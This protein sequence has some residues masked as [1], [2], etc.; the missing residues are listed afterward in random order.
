MKQYLF[1]CLFTTQICFGQQPLRPPLAKSLKDHITFLADDKLEGRRAGSPGEAL[2]SAYVIKEFKKA[3]LQ[4]APG[5]T[6]FLQAFEIAE[7]KQLG[8]SNSLIVGSK[9]FALNTD[10]FPMAF[11][12]PGSV[13]LIKNKKLLADTLDIGALLLQNV[14]NPHFE[15]KAAITAQANNARQSGKPAL[16]LINNSGT[17]DKLHFDK[18]DKTP[19]V[20]IPVIFIR[21]RQQFMLA[22]DATL[23]VS[24][25]DT[26]RTGHNVIGYIDNKATTTVVLGAHY[27]HLGYGEDNNSLYSGEIKMIHNGA[28][29][30]ASGTAA[31]IELAKMVKNSGIKNNNYIFVAFS[32]E[33]LGLFGS[34]FFV[35][36]FTAGLG[37][38]NYMINMDMLGRLN[39]ST[40][41]LTIGGYGTSPLWNGIIKQD[42][43]YFK[44]KLDSS[45]SG[46]SD[47]TSFYRKNIPVLFFFTGTH[48]DY[49]KPSDDAD[50]INFEGEARVVNY[51]YTVIVQANNL[52]RLSFTKTREAAAMG[53][54][55]F[56]VTLGIMPD[57]TFSGNGVLVDGVSDGRPAQK[58]GV[59]TG[60]VLLQLGDHSFSDVND[61]MKALNKFNKGES[62]KLKLQR[63][64]K[65]MLFEITF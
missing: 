59:Q 23:S 58:A 7:G 13:A 5:H 44:I 28:D 63:A 8:D 46:P 30:N 47:H 11:S 21:N 27:D 36:N 52:D 65:E 48:K 60:D 10:Y 12:G 17:D 54:S 64:G 53:K 49:H 37:S 14:M 6:D 18:N 4:I 20:K 38:I 3:G 16:I 22:A 42:D 43:S 39:D 55:N 56:K 50:K 1:L 62:T 31:L 15:L 41:G 35:D 61:Y 51:I 24:V 45:G 25:E 9:T 26:K 34:K 2:A 32:G 19:A 33:E 29:D 57:Y 40:H